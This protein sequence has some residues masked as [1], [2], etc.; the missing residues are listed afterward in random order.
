MLGRCSGLWFFFGLCFVS[1][2]VLVFVEG[3]STFL[4]GGGSEC[5]ALFVP[6]H[7]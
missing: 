3:A 1:G 4:R 6:L 2:Q 5:S 7:S